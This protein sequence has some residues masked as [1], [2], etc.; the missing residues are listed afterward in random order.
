MMPHDVSGWSEPVRNALADHAER[1]PRGKSREKRLR[2]SLLAR[3]RGPAFV[4]FPAKFAGSGHASGGH[5]TGSEGRAAYGGSSPRGVAPTER[6]AAR[7]RGPPAYGV[8]G[9]SLYAETAGSFSSSAGTVS[10]G[11]AR[12]E[13][14]R[15][16]RGIA[17]PPAGSRDE[18]RAPELAG[19][20]GRTLPGPHNREGAES[21][22]FQSQTRHCPGTRGEHRGAEPRKRRARTAGR[23]VPAAQGGG[24]KLP[25][26]HPPHTRA[27][28]R[29]GPR[30]CVAVPRTGD[31][32]WNPLAEAR[33]RRGGIHLRGADGERTKSVARARRRRALGSV[34]RERRGAR[35]EK[36]R[37]APTSHDQGA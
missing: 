34:A 24:A 20:S 21:S 4:S 13:E 17:R 27:P 36:T 18:R 19:R 22:V 9:L 23:R 37:A 14:E 1:R 11:P 29:P 16:P 12:R 30:R 26:L 15:A 10:E 31:P 5:P 2:E 33:S 3:P 35:G 32:P 7:A 28:R 8:N 25:P 6:E